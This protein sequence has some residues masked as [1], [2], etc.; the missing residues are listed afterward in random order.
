MADGQVVDEVDPGQ[1]RPL[2][3]EWT[4]DTRLA[5][6]GASGVVSI[7]SRST[8]GLRERGP[9]CCS[10]GEFSLVLTEGKPNPFAFYGNSGEGRFVDLETGATAVV[11]MSPHLL[12]EGLIGLFADTRE[13][14]LLNPSGDALLVDGLGALVRKVPVPVKHIW[15]DVPLVAPAGRPFSEAPPSTF[16]V[17]GVAE[18]ERTAVLSLEV[19]DIDASTMD[20]ID[21]PTRID[22]PKPAAKVSLQYGSVIAV[23]YLDSEA[24]RYQFRNTAGAVLAEATLPSPVEWAALAGDGRHVV[25]SNASDDSV[26]VVDTRDGRV[27]VLPVYAE[28]QEPDMLSDGRFMIQTREGQYELWDAQGPTRIG[29]LADPGP[30]AWTWP[31]VARDESHVWIVLDGAW[32]RIP[33]DPR[34]W[35]DRACALVG[36]SITEQEWRDFVPGERPYN[37]ACAATA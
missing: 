2:A 35:R 14:V 3:L 37:D 23:K 20:M 4:G 27:T 34:E 11:D 19:A 6:L 33:L 36:R 13:Q 31:S 10:P 32:T 21:G 17:V 8:G 18:G 15:D 5:A 26:R 12:E 16:T 1:Q 9:P 24:T 29:A 22:L 25:A 7:L 28:P 30:Y